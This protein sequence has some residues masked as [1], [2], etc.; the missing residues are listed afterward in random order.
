MVRMLIVGDRMGLR[1]K[2]RLCEEVHLNT[3]RDLERGQ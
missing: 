3:G 1:L 2:R